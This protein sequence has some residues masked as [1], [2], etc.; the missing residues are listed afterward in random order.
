MLPLTEVNIPMQLVQH[1]LPGNVDT[2]IIDGQI[3][4][5]NGE[6]LGVDMQQVINETAQSQARIRSRA[7][8]VIDTSR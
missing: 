3:R 7:G 4:K 1:G 8:E 5:L 6:L 2:V